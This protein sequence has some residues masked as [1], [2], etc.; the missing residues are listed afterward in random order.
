MSASA[1]VVNGATSRDLVAQPSWWARLAPY[2][3]EMALAVL[4]VVLFVAAAI[5]SPSFLDLTTQRALL[6]HDWELAMLTLPMML[7]I[8]TGGIDLSVGA[9]MALASV[10]FGLAFTRTG[11]VGAAVAAALGT[12]VV[13]GGLNGLCITRFKVHP[14]IVT[15]ATLSAYRGIAEGMSLGQSV[16]GFPASFSQIA[17]MTVAGIPLLGGLYLIFALMLAFKLARTPVGAWLVAMG[18]N[19]TAARF[20]AVRVDR[21]KVAL[22]TYS[23]LMAGAAA[24]FFA[25]R[26]NTAKADV[27]MGMEL[28]VIT[29][30]VLGGTSIF[31]GRGTVIGTVLGFL[32]LH[33]SREWM[34]W[35]FDYDELNLIL[36]GVLLIASV[37]LQR[38][39]SGRSGRRA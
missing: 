21:L 17:T 13:C 8:L 25:A 34:S 22:Y 26:R 18:Y 19:E 20:A 3:H 2:R 14:L 29:A 24:I 1:P 4:L 28:D 35:A 16:S 12:G 39:L 9:T 32:L 31:G 10:V 7:I 36:V 15:L 5:V 11:S 6:S 33:E 27:G 23:G 30:V 38:V 37:L